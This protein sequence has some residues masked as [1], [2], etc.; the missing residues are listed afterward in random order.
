MSEL[1]RKTLK[2]SGGHIVANLTEYEIKKAKLGGPDL[3]LGAVGRL[4]KD[5]IV[6]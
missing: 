2:G 3:F 5:K 6:N 4:D 1:E